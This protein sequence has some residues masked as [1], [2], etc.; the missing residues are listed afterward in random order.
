MELMMKGLSEKER[1][2]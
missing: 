2:N 1:K